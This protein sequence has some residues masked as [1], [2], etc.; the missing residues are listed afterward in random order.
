L[1]TKC[2]D[3]KTTLF[4]IDAGECARWHGKRNNAERPAQF[5]A[6]RERLRCWSDRDRFY[7]RIGRGRIRLRLFGLWCL[8]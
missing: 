6:A 3:T 8:S 4:A 2:H 5:S 1:L 7:R